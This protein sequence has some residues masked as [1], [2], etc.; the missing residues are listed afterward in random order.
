MG[1]ELIKYEEKKL[2][3]IYSFTD[4]KINVAKLS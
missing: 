3:L 4:D 1:A 2:N